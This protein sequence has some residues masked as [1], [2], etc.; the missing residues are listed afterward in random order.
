MKPIKLKIDTKTQKYPIIIGSNLISN[1][2]TIIKKNSL[3]FNKCLLIVDK[4]ISKK[5]ISKIKKSL[6][7]K[8]ISVYLFKA[9]EIN[10][11]LNYVNKILNILLIKN[12]SREDCLISIGGGITGDIS[13]FAANRD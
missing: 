6:I 7:K 11:N 3:E 4:N 10:K 12:F 1:I 9:S 8:D 13:G 2:S 5:I